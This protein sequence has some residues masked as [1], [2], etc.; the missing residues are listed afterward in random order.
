MPNCFFPLSS[1]GDQTELLYTLSGFG[2]PSDLLPISC[3]G[4][5]KTANHNSWINVQRTRLFREQ[6]H[7]D[8]EIVECPRSEDVVFKKGPGY[9]N[10]PGNLYFRGLIEVAGH[11]HQN[12]G[13]ERKYELTMSI[14][15]QIEEINGRFLQWS[16]ARK[17]WVVNK[18]R[19]AIRTKV[20]SMIKQ[21]NRQRL[22]S[23]QLKIAIA[24]A[25]AVAQPKAQENNKIEGGDSSSEEGSLK[26][27]YSVQNTY[28]AKKRRKILP[29]DQCLDATKED[30]KL[31]F[32]KTFF[33]TNN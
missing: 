2:I 23:Q 24:T 14:V 31:C 4:K 25:V 29:C 7:T 6:Y 26:H 1:E 20:A 33:P 28:Y 19:N 30:D 18:D 15:Q 13:K 3:T 8:E 10:N 9:R 27:H 16:K 12:A 5:V 22:E 32:G 17:M 11:E 21:Y